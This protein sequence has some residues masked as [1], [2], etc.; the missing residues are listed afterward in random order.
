[1]KKVFSWALVFLLCLTILP[2]GLVRA[3]ETPVLAVGDQSV[4]FV[5]RDG[6]YVASATVTPE[7]K[8]FTAG[9]GALPTHEQEITVSEERLLVVNYHDGAFNYKLLPLKSDGVVMEDVKLIRYPEGAVP[10]GTEVTFYVYTPRRD[11]SKVVLTLTDRGLSDDQAPTSGKPKAVK[12]IELTKVAESNDGFYDVW[13][14]KFTPE[15]VTWY[16]Y[17]A[18][19]YDGSKKRQVGEGRLTVYD[20]DFTTP[21]WLKNAVIY[22][23]F[24]DRFKN[25]NPENDVTE[26]GQKFTFHDDYFDEDFTLPGD[27]M[28]QLIQGANWADPVTSWATV[29]MTDGSK[30]CGYVDSYRFY[31]G[32]LE[33]IIEELDY[34][35]SLGITAIYLNPIFPSETTHRYDPASYFGVDPRLGDAETFKKLTE[36]A[37]KRGIKIIN[38]I[39]PDHSGDDSL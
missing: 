28:G 29:T 5:Y 15:E 18:Y 27:Y 24:P 39:T 34:L 37:A 25:G 3:Q 11:V 19:A 16:Q 33:G 23:I 26:E 9:G 35:K 17:V 2:A 38:D 20:P 8:K 36:E 21:D 6:Y 4:P 22:Q 14:Y 32:D 7:V 13:S 10:A 12:D 1:V 31:G 30:K